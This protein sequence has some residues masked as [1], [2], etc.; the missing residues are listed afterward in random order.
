MSGESFVASLRTATPAEAADIKAR[1]RGPLAPVPDAAAGVK[2]GVERWPVK[3]GTDDD[4]AKVGTVIV[5]TTVQE[6]GNFPRPAALQPPTSDPPSAQRARFDP[7]ETTVWRLSANV[8]AFKM[9]SDGDYHLVLQDGTGSTMIAEVPMP[10]TEFIDSSTFFSD[11]QAARAAVDAR[12]SGTVAATEFAPGVTGKL[13]PRDALA[14]DAAAN[15]SGTSIRLADIAT[16]PA[17]A[18]AFAMRI[19][20]VAATLTGIGFFDRDHGQTGRAPNIVELHPVLSVTFAPGA[21][22]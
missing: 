21:T 19:T 18:R 20:P 7:V 15:A 12:F 10:T 22:P 13:V 16:D 2:P 14:P 17:S 8:I 1:A 9:E 4:V 11:I 6:I 5:D 3:T